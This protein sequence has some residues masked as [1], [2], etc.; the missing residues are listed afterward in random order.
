M[1][2]GRPG[3]SKQQSPPKKPAKSK[4]SWVRSGLFALL[5]AISGWFALDKIIP[6]GMDIYDSIIPRITAEAK[7]DPA[8]IHN[9]E[10]TFKNKGELDLRDVVLE[11][12]LVWYE[13]EGG[14]PVA[15][16]AQD[17]H[18]PQGRVTL[19][20][21]YGYL[22]ELSSHGGTATANLPELLRGMIQTLGVKR[23]GI[24]QELTYQMFPFDW[25][26]QWLP[27]RFHISKRAWEVGYMMDRSA[28]V[29]NWRQYSCS[30][31]RKTV[32]DRKADGR[33]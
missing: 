8:A 25:L 27:K 32:P 23:I 21:R 5:T 12:V 11:T 14:L 29:N 33:P 4:R 19:G 15:P 6:L 24:C 2:R 17:E 31:V 30:A 16:Y 1:S 22:G 9:V 7:A 10:F 28:G 3:G 26:S 18:S 13:T 20:N